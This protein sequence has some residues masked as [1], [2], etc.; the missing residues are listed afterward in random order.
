MTFQGIYINYTLYDGFD[1]DNGLIVKYYTNN[2]CLG[3]PLYITRIPSSSISSNQRD[4]NWYLFHTQLKD[5]SVKMTTLMY[6]PP[7]SGKRLSFVTGFTSRFQLN[8]NDKIVMTQGQTTGMVNI[9]GDGEWVKVEMIYRCTGNPMTG[10]P[11][12]IVQWQSS[13][14]SLQY[15]ENSPRGVIV[16]AMDPNDL[17]EPV[18]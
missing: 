10:V 16:V 12:F 2:N 15:L 11:A 3:K 4:S 1:F 7:G 13:F 9:Q 17:D 6:V 5:F 8:V 14:V 18:L